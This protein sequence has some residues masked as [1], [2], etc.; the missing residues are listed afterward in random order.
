M[1]TE[2]RRSHGL[3]GRSQLRAWYALQLLVG[4]VAAL[5]VTTPP[6]EPTTEECRT[7][8]AET[9]A[10]IPA[11]AGERTPESLGSSDR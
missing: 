11:C 6:P 7:F 1:S 2:K 10:V 3:H 5:P 9:R 4:L 8:S